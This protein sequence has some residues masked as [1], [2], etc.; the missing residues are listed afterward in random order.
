MNAKQTVVKEQFFFRIG[1]T[2]IVLFALIFGCIGQSQATDSSLWIAE[3]E[4]AIKLLTTTGDVDFEI[5]VEGGIESLAVSQQDQVVWTFASKQLRS[6]E[7]NGTPLQIIDISTVISNGSVRGLVVTSDRIFLAVRKR[8][9]IFDTSGILLFE[10]QHDRRVKGITLDTSRDQLWLATLE[11]VLVYDN[12]GQLIQSMPMPN[13]DAEEYRRIAYDAFLDQVWISLS[14]KR[15]RRY[16]PSGQQVFETTLNKGVLRKFLSPDGNGGLWASRGKKMGHI[17]NDGQLEFSFKPFAEDINP[18]LVDLVSDPA[19]QSVWVS[20]A[21]TLKRYSSAGLQ[22]LEIIPGLGDGIIRGINQLNIQADDPTPMVIVLKPVDGSNINIS[23]PPIELEVEASALNLNDL[24]IIIDAVDAEPNCILDD[25]SNPIVITCTLITALIDGEHHLQAQILNTDGT[26]AA[27][28][29]STF[30]VDTVIPIITITSPHQDATINT[31]NIN[32]IGQVNEPASITIDG[33]TVPLDI[34]NEFNHP[35]VLLGGPNSIEIIAEDPAGNSDSQ[36]LNLIFEANTQPTITS[37]P[38]T[39]AEEGGPYIYAVIVEDTDNDPLSYHLDQFPIGMTINAAGLIQWGSPTPGT[40]SVSIRV[41][42]GQGGIA[43]QSYSLVV[44]PNQ[45]PVITSSPGTAGIIDAQYQYIIQ[46][47]DPDGGAISYSLATAPLGMQINNNVITWTPVN[48]GSASVTL[49]VADIGGSQTQQSYSINVAY[50][51][52]NQPPQFTA[53]SDQIIPLGTHKTVQFSAVDPEGKTIDYNVTPLPLP[54]GAAFNRRSGLFSF[55]PKSADQ[56]GSIALTFIASDDRHDI[57]QTVNFTVTAPPAN[58]PTSFSGR[59]TDANS[60]AQGVDTPIV[61]ATVFFLGTSITSTTGSD[62]YFTLENIPTGSELIFAIDGS[63]ANPAPGGSGYASF[64]ELLTLI[65]N[66]ANIEERSFFMPR[67]DT[68]SLTQVVPVAPAT[69]VNDDLGIT[70]AVPANTAKNPDGSQFTGQISI[71]EVPRDLAPAAMPE[72]LDPGL[73]IT[74]QPA[75]LEFTTPV[76]ITFPNV[77]EL[78]PGSE[79]DIWSVNPTTGQFEIVGIGRVTANGESVETISGGIRRADWHMALPQPPTPPTDKPDPDNPG[80]CPAQSGSTTCLNDGKM[81]NTFS[82][83]AYRSLE[84]NRSWSFVYQTTRAAPQPIRSF[85]TGAVPN[86]VVPITISAKIDVGGS[87]SSDGVDQGERIFFDVS[88]LEAGKDIVIGLS[89][90]AS[91]FKSG[92]Y[93]ST[94]EV[95]NRFAQSRVGVKRPTGIQIVNEKDSSFGAGWMLDGLSKLAIISETSEQVESVLWISP[96]GHHQTYYKFPQS[97]NFR[98]PSGSFSS[99][100]KNAGGTYTLT[101]KYGK[102]SHYN[103][104]G[105]MVRSEDRNGNVTS[106]TYGVNDQLQRITDPVGLVTTL[107]YASRRM[108]SIIDPAGRITEFRH[109]SNGNLIEVIYPDNSRRAYEYSG[110]LMVKKTDERGNISEYQYDAFKR[111]ISATLPDGKK[112]LIRNQSSVG[113]VDVNLGVG[114]ESNPVQFTSDELANATYFDARGN[115]S[116]KLL[117]SRSRV[118][119]SIDEVGRVTQYVRDENSLA[120]RITRPN[121]S[122]INNT[123][124]SKGNTLSNTEQFNGAATTYQYDNFSLVTSTIN[125]RNHTTT[126]NRDTGTGNL[127]SVVNHLG[128]TATYQYDSRGL[129]T[130]SL[131]PNGLQADF[132]YTA[133][134]LVETRVETPLSGP[135]NVRTTSYSYNGAGLLQT[136]VTPDNITYNFTYD[137][138]SR[139]TGYT[140]NLGQKMLITYDEFG[141]IA[142]MQTLNADGSSALSNSNKYDQRNR[143]IENSAPHGVDSD[144][145]IQYLLDP[146]SN[147]TGTIDPNGNLNESAYDASNRLARFTHRENGITDY[148]YDSLDRIT[149]VR[150]PNG[151]TTTFTYDVL[152]RRLTENSSDRGTIRYSYDLANNTTQIIDARG[153]T[154]NYSYDELERLTTKTFPNSVEDITYSYDSCT[155]GVG[156]LCSI[157]DESG[158]YAYSYDAFGN[159]IQQDKQELGQ[160]YST[161][162]SY[163]SGNNIIAMQ[164]PTGRSLNIQRDGIRRI[165]AIDATINSSQQTIISNINYRG[166]NQ[167]TQCTFGNGLT[168]NRTYDQQGRLQSQ[169]LGSIDNRSYSYDPNGNI[170]QRSTTP[171]VSEH[172]YDKLDRITSDTIDN[173]I[174]N[175]FSYDLNHNRLS[176]VLQDDSLQTAYGYDSQSN[177]LQAIESTIAGTDPLPGQPSTNRTYNNANRWFELYEEGNKKADYIYNSLGQRTRKTIYNPDTTPASITIYHYD[178]TGKLIAETSEAGQVQR[179]YIWSNQTPVAQIDHSTIDNQDSVNYLHTDHLLTPRLATNNAQATVWRW[180]GEVFGETMADENPDGDA[181]LTT[182]NLRFPGQYFDSESGLHYN[183]FRDYDPTLGRYLQSDPIGLRAGLNTYGYAYQNSVMYIDP[184][185]LNPIVKQLKHIKV[186]GPRA[187]KKGDGTGSLFQIRYKNK[188]VFRVDLHP[189]DPQDRTPIPHFHIAPDM[190]KHREFPEFLKEPIKKGIEQCLK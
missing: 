51:S 151:V 66:V 38:I 154:A 130:Q 190:K 168:D 23:T 110:H 44:T 103:T 145:V 135:G 182:V 4:G 94:L 117:D 39:V 52:D 176:K 158:S 172:Q 28:A 43:T 93:R 90:D 128:H 148:Q 134:G 91:H 131:S 174:A 53:V 101:D 73:L 170:L 173:G 122:V 102:K 120:T 115:R 78:P 180:E 76:P 163:D 59:I 62:G 1:S 88:T 184:D 74:I 21:N 35:L 49:I 109:D 89:F 10:T 3:S 144:S 160:S 47:N 143:L 5:P 162:Y 97:D 181:S 104:Q 96:D 14:E 46:A 108:Q 132:S 19:D 71:S 166:D 27:G 69:V 178:L 7:L 17:T 124:D 67:I 136:L 183:Y 167:V 77:D 34:N 87:P 186:D 157:Q 32:I 18:T 164:Y 171:Q 55:E 79:L 72:L 92:I 187:S 150:A 113:L 127:L 185:G 116:Q 159:I 156:Y 152:G 13:E 140:D 99:L 11:H 177:R 60:M 8:L 22:E 111:N 114:T 189:I 147:V 188:P 107:T 56:V 15:L 121:G 20:N 31:A 106:F 141:N 138:R 45:P 86:S 161:Q 30:T 149:L 129:I 175:N 85:T 98:T 42:D 83:P 54:D 139:P 25:T 57:S 100:V 36:T 119:Q 133:E 41:E 68:T 50:A 80:A 26:V 24:K 137:Q 61:G 165:S 142:S 16:S 40:V 63:T 123:F 155:L 58:T 33:I 2:T 84:T 169:Q 75:G 6:Y 153:I 82:L 70:L 65:P 37:L 9:Y 146:E 29:E 64:R 179:D 125:P 118:V 81:T 126:Y 12:D 48:A 105:L 95:F 112:R